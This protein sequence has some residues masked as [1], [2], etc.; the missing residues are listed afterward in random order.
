MKR[1]GARAIMLLCLLC[2]LML[3][4]TVAWQHFTATRID[5]AQAQ[6]KARHWLSVLPAELYD[7]QPLQQPLTLPQPQ[8]AHS[9]LLAAYRAT[10]QGRTHAVVLH[11]EA[12]GYEGPIQ[13]L[14][15]IDREG[16]VI[17][18]KVLRHQETPGLGATV[19]EPGNRWLGAFAGLSQANTPAGA[20]GLKRDQ[21]QFDQIAGASVTSRAVIHAVQDALRYYDTQAPQ[22]LAGEQP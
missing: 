18:V 22:W 19:A 1:I 8:L 6:L 17:A 3:G 7:N 16:R 14:I 15:A 9:R 13:L 10:L 4:A 2:V 12:S 11:S 21:G 20:W 5:D